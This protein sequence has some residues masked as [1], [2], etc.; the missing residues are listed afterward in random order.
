MITY[1]FQC[2]K[3]EIGFNIN[4]KYDGFFNPSQIKY[5]PICKHEM[6]RDYRRENKF[7][8]FKGSG[9]YSTDNKKE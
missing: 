8:Q 5:C 6:Y 4:I 3:C 7:I 2:D 1:C 9:F